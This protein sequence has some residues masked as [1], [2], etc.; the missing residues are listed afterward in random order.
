MIFK[1]NMENSS[2]DDNDKEQAKPK[3][4]KDLISDFKENS[5]ESDSDVEISVEPDLSN[6]EESPSK[7]SKRKSAPDANDS[8][9]KGTLNSM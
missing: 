7:K 1:V 9:K 4:A 2:L 8:K 3:T 5:D 6:G